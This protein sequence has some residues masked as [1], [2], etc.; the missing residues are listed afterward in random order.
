MIL[1]RFFRLRILMVPMA[2]ALVIPAIFASATALGQS[3][4]PGTAPAPGLSEAEQMRKH[5]EL[6]RMKAET[7]RLT[8]VGK[9]D[10]AAK[11]AVM[12]LAL[13]REVMGEL[14]EDVIG[15][16]LTLARLHESREDWAARTALGEVIAIRE[17]QPNRKAWRI[18]DARR[19]LADFERR[20]ALDPRQR[21]QLQEAD[22]LDKLL[23]EHYG[24]GK[25]AEGIVPGRQA[26]AIRRELLGEDHPDYADSLNN[27]GMLYQN[28]GDYAKAEPLLRQALEIRKRAL[29]E[30]H[31]DYAL[32]LNN[33]GMLYQ[34]TGDYAKAEPL[35]CQAL[36]IRKR[37]LGEDHRDY[38]DSL[39]NLGAL[40]Q[41][42]G[43]YSKAEP[44]LRRALEIHR[45]ALGEDHPDYALS[46]HNLGALYRDMGDYKKAEPLYRQALE[47]KKRAL[48]EDHPDY[49]LSLSNLGVLYQNTREDAKAEPLLRQVVEIHRRALGENHPYYALSLNNLGVLYLDMGDDAKA[50]P[51]LRQALEIR[52]RTLGENHT[53]YALSLINLGIL[54]RGM[55]NYAKAEPLLRQALEIHRRVLGED[56]PDYAHSQNQLGILYLDMGDDAKAEPLLRQALEIRK[57]TLGENHTDYATS[58]DHLGVLYQNTGDYA[59]A[60]SLLRQ[61]L[62]IRKRAL[63]EDHI[64]YAQ[65]LNKLGSLSYIRGQLVAGEQYSGQAL[66]SL[67]RQMP[68]LFATLGERRRIRVLGTH[69][70]YLMLYL[71]IAPA[72]GINA[73]DIYRRVLA[74]KGIVEA[75]QDEDRLTRD[76]PGL[77]GAFQQ[78][79]EARSDLARK[80]FAVPPPDRRQAWRQQFDAI[81]DRKDSLEDELARKSAA[82]RRAREPRRL[83]AAEVAAALP[84]ATA[85]VD[86]LDYLHYSPPEGGKGPLRR[87]RRLVAF[88]LS[89]GRAP[90]LV[91]LGPS[92]P[93]D[94]AVRTWREAL[95]AGKS[96]P[97]EAAALDLGHRVWGPIKPHL[98]GA[99]TVLVAPDGALASFPLAALPGERP[100]TYLLEDLAIGYV[101]SASRLVE[102]LAAPAE[103]LGDGP[104]AD[105]TGLLAVGGIDYQVDPGGAPSTGSSPTP[106]VLV[107]DSDRAGFK[108]LAGTG[109]EARQ[110]GKLFDAAFPGQ[111]A[112]ILTGAEP[113]E[114][115]I[116]QHLGRHWQYLHLA[117]H[118]FFESPARVAA[119]RAGPGSDGFGFSL[120][121]RGDSEDSASLALAPFLHSGVALAGAARKPET[122]GPAGSQPDRD[123]GILTAE[124][125]QSLDLRGTE[126]VVLSAC[127]TGLGKTGENYN[128]Q[129]VLGLQRA[130]QSAGA[131]AVVASLWK[132][133][134]VATGLLMEQ[135]YANLWSRKLPKLEALRQAQL[136]VLNSPG[137]VR[138][139]RTELAGRR[140]IDEKAEK[141]PKGEATPTTN[142]PSQ[143]SDPALWAAF[144]LSGDIR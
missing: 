78:L 129:G 21:R 90:V 99:S 137:L 57:R 142:A 86:L 131:R 60:E 77:R 134:D 1:S 140:G 115:A 138:A 31:P 40:Y 41:S 144:V 100:G 16:L 27:L 112:L 64:L 5:R 13:T 2:T 136:T 72:A 67:T 6:D 127:E 122:A 116:K 92:A 141:L 37:A 75:R 139:R 12:E 95:V 73:E 15:S 8:T 113:T 20:A 130:V 91:P 11:S 121:G 108:S 102:T 50:E 133:D 110:V 58:L 54:Y 65:C 10:E 87:E 85:F 101:S 9:L 19:S 132:V 76:Q 39:N 106:G 63:S 47:I 44:L 66:T 3:Q 29:G 45:W 35:Y 34:N 125:V 56:H 55:R 126:L 135:F 46:L 61:A 124:E 88:V 143:R 43:A 74:W 33:L 105:A 128:G 83:G 62:E 49:A 69:G 71:S 103:D 30:D 123:D 117:T 96:A 38:A 107:V 18:G 114:G 28:T 118:G 89:R 32:S 97:M 98:G 94:M 120:P 42:M 7:T 26:M 119:L 17:R 36:E 53:D 84:P 93:V 79:G 70:E 48:G 22:R 23:V 4:S 25:Y 68:E 24:Q 59:K 111:H 14:H 104:G 52:K 80:A 51:L 81:L 82:F 109:P